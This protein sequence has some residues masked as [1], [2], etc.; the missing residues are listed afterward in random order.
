V[1]SGKL[2]S[3]SRRLVGHH[4]GHGV[5]SMKVVASGLRRFFEAL[6][7]LIIRLLPAFVLLIPRFLGDV[8][9]AI[10][11]C[12]RRDSGDCCLHLPPAVHK[13]ADPLIYDQYYLLANGISVTWDNPDIDIFDGPTLVNPWEL[14]AGHVYD[15]RVRCWNGSY[16][17]PAINMPVHLSFLSF[18]VGTTTNYVGTTPTDLGVKGSAQCPAFADFTWKTPEKPG[19]Y[20]LQ[21]Y[22][23]WPDD[24]NPLNNLG[25][26]NTQ[27]G[28]MHSPA[29]FD[30][31]VHNDAGVRRHVELEADMYELPQLPPCAESE[32]DRRTPP[33]RLQESRNRWAA[34]RRTQAFGEFPVTAPWSVSIEPRAFVLPA[35]ATATVKV[36]IDNADSTFRGRQAFNVHGFATIEN[37]ERTPLGGVT[38]FVERS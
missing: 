34:A 15:V 36:R 14:V 32:P 1:A 37:R 25:Q 27:V 4:S 24:A 17:A 2:G 12:R 26:K 20:C 6:V 3:A 30:V 16:D 19:H 38:L 13:R 22:L 5:K 7:E 10:R 35:H 23:E 33:T 9:R 21:A 8:G 11:R 28:A 29:E 31:D 18:G